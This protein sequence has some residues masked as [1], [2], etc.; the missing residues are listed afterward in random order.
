M[1]P[2]DAKDIATLVVLLN[3][4]DGAETAARFRN[5]LDA[6]GVALAQIESYIDVANAT[7]RAQA[8]DL[9]MA[10]ATVL[11]RTSN[12]LEGAHECLQTMYGLLPQISLRPSLTPELAVLQHK[13]STLQGGAS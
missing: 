5:Q 8:I 6:V 7:L 9:D 4:P 10:V 13:L 3:R 11:D 2:L 1:N 12:L